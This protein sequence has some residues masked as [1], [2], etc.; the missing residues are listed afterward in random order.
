M[1]TPDALNKIKKRAGM[2]A[3]DNELERKVY[4]VFK[5]LMIT[6]RTITLK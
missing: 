5:Y 4:L 6:S 1:G 3:D 2:R